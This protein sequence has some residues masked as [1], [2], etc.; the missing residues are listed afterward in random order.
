VAVAA[1]ALAVFLSFCLSTS[2]YAV[3]VQR[4]LAGDLEAWL[5]EDHSNP[6][7]AVKIAFRGGAALDPP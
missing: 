1:L 4:V 6:M 7:I 3:D 5:V 2:A